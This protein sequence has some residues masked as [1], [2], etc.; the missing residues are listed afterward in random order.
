MTADR[1]VASDV[2]RERRLADARSSGDHDQVARLQPRREVVEVAEPRRQP[3][4]GRVPV[5]D[6]LEV[7]HRLVDQVAEDGDLVGVLPAGDVVDALLCI[8]GHPFG[9]GRRRVRH[10]HD[11]G[12]RADQAPEQRRLRDDARVVRGRG[13]RRDLLDEV[14]HVQGTAD[15]LENA[16][17]LQRLDTGDDVD[18][19]ALGVEPAEHV[20]DPA[21]GGAIEVVG[22]QDFD[23]ISDSFGREHHRPQHRIFRFKILGRFSR[24]DVGDTPYILNRACQARPAPSRSAGVA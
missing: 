6:D 15:V 9:V 20:V 14:P 1:D 2:R 7:D 23:D 18:G 4:V 17:A 16:G 13:G 24:V 10:V 12:R 11:V 8:V 22:L 21:V 19:L 5:L 3:G